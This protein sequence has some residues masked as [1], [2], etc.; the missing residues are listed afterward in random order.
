MFRRPA[1]S[2]LAVTFF[3]ALSAHASEFVMSSAADFNSGQYALTRLEGTG[4]N[5]QLTLSATASGTWAAT[6]IT[7]GSGVALGTD[8]ERWL[9]ALAGAV[10]QP[11]L[12]I[13]TTTDTS[14]SYSLS[15]GIYFQQSG[16]VVMG[17][18][19]FWIPFRSSTLIP[20]LTAFVPSTQTVLGFPT[21][22]IE[23]VAGTTI[24]S[25]LV[26]GS[27]GNIYFFNSSRLLERLNLSD[28]SFT[29]V[30]TSPQPAFCGQRI[31]AGGPGYF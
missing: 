21:V 12:A 2:F 4:T 18:T 24:T 28:S 23:S 7:M 17:G 13:D 22:P 15:T 14:T 16:P 3:C 6:G 8:R 25:D 9:Y 20:P 11:L 26:A 5:T 29:T 31:T 30:G 1:Y 19:V 10:A 27:D